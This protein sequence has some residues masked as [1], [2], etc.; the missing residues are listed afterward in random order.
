MIS[1]YII[2]ALTLL[3][4]E[5]VY[6]PIAR[7]FGIGDNP[8]NRSS[9]KNFS[10]TGGGFIFYL[11]AILFYIFNPETHNDNSLRYMITCAS[12]LAIISFIDDI[13]DVSPWFRLIVQF[14]VVALTFHHILI[15]G[16]YHVFLII[17]LFGVGFI[18]A[19]NFMDGING[20]TVAF[21]TVTLGTL[22]YCNSITP[23]ISMELIVS[24]LISVGI[25]GIFNFHKKAICFA[26]DIGAIVMGFFILFLIMQ[27]CLA[28]SNAS[29]VVFL[30][31]Y[32][33]DTVYTI[34][35]RLFMGE[36]IFLPHRR[37]LYQVFAN[38][39][40]IPHFAVSLGYAMTQ[41]SINIIYFFIPEEFQWSYVILVTILLS[42]FY[43]LAKRAPK[44]RLE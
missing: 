20:I 17:L 7:H 23:F 26:G 37:H 38:Q 2:L 24:L 43:F 25:F 33:I 29:Y 36:N 21:S 10:I 5:L 13:K 14:I 27:L 34:F 31:V 30:I 42:I 28:T 44:S 40:K 9:H 41:L 11:S 19:F 6:I 16:Y 8:T 3:I 32:G 18:N 22:A 39:W 15:N 4:C 35:Q 12:I 1:Y